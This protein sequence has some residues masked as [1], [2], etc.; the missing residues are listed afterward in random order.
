[1]LNDSRLTVLL[2]S[3]MLVAC[4]SDT[5]TTSSGDPSG[6]AGAVGGAGSGTGGTAA[7]TGGG[8][9]GSFGIGGSAPTCGPEDE[10]A[11]MTWDGAPVQ[12]ASVNS[13]VVAPGTTLSICFTMPGDEFVTCTST[14]D[15]SP[16]EAWQPDVAVDA[17]VTGMFYDAAVTGEPGFTITFAA[18]DGL[19]Q[20]GS[21]D[22]VVTD[23]S[24]TYT[25]AGTFAACAQ[26]TE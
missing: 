19:T 8:T 18:S 12:S 6:G 17:T 3:L 1:M 26:A 4:G 14:L 21:F 20:D 10:M 22:G 5:T 23:G 24:T 15:M 2:S 16:T 11:S 13:L 25:V 7:G 9:G